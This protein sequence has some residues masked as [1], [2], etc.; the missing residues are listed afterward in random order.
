[1]ADF[2]TLYGERLS[3]ALSSEDTSEL[4][5]TDRRKAAI[6]EAQQWFNDQT[7]CLQRTESITLLD[8][9]GLYD[10]EAEISDA[11]FM[12]IAAQGPELTITYASGSV[13]CY[14]GPKDFPRRTIAWLNTNLPG[15]RQLA[16]GLP[17]GWYEQQE[18]GEYNIGIVPAPDIAGGD[19]WVLAVPYVVKAPA[20]V[21]D[22]DQPFEIGNNPPAHLEPYHDAL[23]L[24]AAG[25]LEPLRRDWDQS[26]KLKTLAMQRVVAYKDRHA[27]KVG[28]QRVQQVYTGWPRRKRFGVSAYE[29]AV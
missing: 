23:E 16:D 19:T 27:K 3:R 2:S 1:M 8:G 10:L 29:D 17:V 6:N 4:F 9:D 26:I 5:T 20:L 18:G 22:N 12:R 11:D 25:L 21:N 13:V 7:E 24:Y 28:G 15:W 14:A